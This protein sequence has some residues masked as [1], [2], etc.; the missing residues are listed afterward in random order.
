MSMGKQ[1][2]EPITILS[3]RSRSGE[4]EDFG[5]IDLRMGDVVNVVGPTGSGKT[6]LIND[7]ELFAFANTPSGSTAA[8]STT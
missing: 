5:R 2:I 7:L 1:M 4:S 6:T 8:S 3:G